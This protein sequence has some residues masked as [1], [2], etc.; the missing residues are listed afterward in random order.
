M[1]WTQLILALGAAA[2]V[3][4]RPQGLGLRLGTRGREREE[5]GLGLP[6]RIRG[7]SDY[8]DPNDGAGWQGDVDFGGGGYNNDANPSRAPQGYDQ[9]GYDQPQGYGDEA[10]QQGY[11]QAPQPRRRGR[12]GPE[13][14]G[15]SV[16]NE[17]L[18]AY[19]DS[20]RGKVLLRVG[21]LVQGVIIGEII[22]GVMGRE[23]GLR[24][25]LGLACGLFALTFAK[26]D[27]GEFSR[28]LGLAL[29]YTAEKY[30]A[31]RGAFP[32]HPHV[33][34]LLRLKPRRPFPGEL[35]GEYNKIQSLLV[36]VLLGGFLAGKVQIPLCP[37]WIRSLGGAAALGL[38]AT[39]EGPLGDLTRTLGAKM[40]LLMGTFL[41][42]LGELGVG[43]LFL[44]NLNTGA[45]F[46]KKVD[47][48]YGIGEKVGSVV[49]KGM[50][51]AQQMMQEEGGDDGYG[52]GYGAPPPRKG[53][54]R[55]PPPPQQ[56]QQ[57]GYDY[58]YDDRRY[59]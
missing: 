36:L 41:G 34:A 58:G 43:G 24:L 15:P 16:Q 42:V 6:L 10:R 44:K 38:A 48:Q 18:Q 35:K 47:E 56:Q 30:W 52:G 37:E 40:L 4:R 22:K 11:G 45:K 8:Y 3:P 13:G 55:P 27:F 9:Q 12:R 39:S 53:R 29:A 2:A 50:S 19:V 28:R 59:Y 25:R 17:E 57:N 26:G 51:A 32:V 49:N 21:A 14:E 54:R 1:R 20:K 23:K 7:G 5:E 46:A 33:L 31:A